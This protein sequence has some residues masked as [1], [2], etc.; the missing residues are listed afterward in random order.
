MKKLNGS[1][2]LKHIYKTRFQG[3]SG[4]EIYF[5]SKGDPPGRYL[6]SLFPY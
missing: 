1:D 4:K 5:D 3:V 2:F 6:T